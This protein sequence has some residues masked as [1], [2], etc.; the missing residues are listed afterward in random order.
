MRTLRF[1]HQVIVRAG[2]IRLLGPNETP[3]RPGIAAAQCLGD[4]P[5]QCFGGKAPFRFDHTRSVLGLVISEAPV[6]V[7]RRSSS[8][9]VGR[10]RRASW[11]TGS[12]LRRLAI[13]A[14]FD[15]EERRQN[16]LDQRW[17]RWRSMLAT[18]TLSAGLLTGA[19]PLEKA[20]EALLKAIGAT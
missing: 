2:H 13:D 4:R 7:T 9:P 15:H 20:L 16:L 12:S 11:S 10:P 17:K 3:L 18:A 19:I 5:P 14:Q 1:V 8:R 6:L